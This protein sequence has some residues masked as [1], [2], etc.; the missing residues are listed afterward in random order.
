MLVFKFGG[1][2][3]K[4]AEAIKNIKTILEKYQEPVIVVISAIGKTTNAL[5]EVC[6]DFFF[7][8]SDINRKFEGI[9]EFHLTIINELFGDRSN[10]V[11]E[12]TERYF[13]DLHTLINRHPGNKYDFYYDSIVSYGELL[14]TLIVSEYLNLNYKYCHFLDIRESLITDNTFREANVNWG[15]S[16]KKI[17]NNFH[18]DGCSKIVTQGFIASSEDGNTTTLGREGSDY[19]AAILAHILDAE[20][21][22]V[23]KDVP[24][25]LNADPKWFRNTVKIDNLSFRETIELSY[26]GA[27]VIHPKTIKPLENKNIPLWVKSFLAPDQSG[28]LIDSNRSNDHLIPAFIFRMNQVL[29]SI[30]TKDLSFVVE[31][32]LSEIFG[33]FSKYRIKINLM[34]NSSTDF[35]VSIDDDSIKIPILIKELQGKYKVRY[36]T[37]LELATIRHFNQETIDRVTVNKKIYLEQRTRLNA[38][39]LMKTI[40]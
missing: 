4:N 39:Y 35:S 22:I 24:G 13:S 15:C 30:S 18:F 11:L 23:W 12:K 32:N 26:Y 27:T 6:N 29:L 37:G 20:K 40:E 36:N 38:R 25:I 1:A 7:N 17:K 3:V 2:S 16:E 14:S 8:G 19:T 10:M 31:E 33:I 5:E 21:M 34:Q 28:T 9:K